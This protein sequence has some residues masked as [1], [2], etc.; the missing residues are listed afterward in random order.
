[1]AVFDLL[2]RWSLILFEWTIRPLIDFNISLKFLSCQ[3][4][5]IGNSNHLIGT[6]FG[7]NKSELVLQ[8][9]FHFL[10]IDFLSEGNEKKNNL[11]F[12]FLLVGL[13]PSLG[14]NWQL[15]VLYGKT[16]LM[17]FCKKYK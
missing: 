6:K 8:Y 7:P 15:L 11:P 3:Y 12:F 1:M 5:I 2:A 16:L 9:F 13:I 10:Y 4:F 14:I 17:D